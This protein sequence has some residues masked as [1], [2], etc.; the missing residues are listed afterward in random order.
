MRD[1]VDRIV[2]QYIHEWS[3]HKID[4]DCS[5]DDA[6]HQHPELIDYSR[7]HMQLVPY[8]ER[9]GIEAILPVFFERLTREPQTQLE[10]ICAHVGYTSRPTW[11]FW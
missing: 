6:V 4:A 8:I 10:R 3:V 1:P 11:H 9:Y 2:S 5:I 7:Y